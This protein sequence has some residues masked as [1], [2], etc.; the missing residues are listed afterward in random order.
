MYVYREPSGKQGR[1]QQ[2]QSKLIVAESPLSLR[3]EIWRFFKRYKKSIYLN[4]ERS[5]LLYISSFFKYFPNTTT[6]LLSS[7]GN[8]NI[9][10]LLLPWGHYIERRW[11]SVSWN[12]LYTHTYYYIHVLCRLGGF[13]FI[14]TL[15]NGNG[16]IFSVNYRV[17]VCMDI[18]YVV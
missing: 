15:E 17:I 12:P 6:R 16:R 5:H 7:D 9:V 14:L 18:G 13:I 2:R 10:N 3:N 8:K 4:D 1:P 11:V